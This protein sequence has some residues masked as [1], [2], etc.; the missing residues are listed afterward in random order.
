[1]AS[2][3]HHHPPETTPDSP[4][5]LEE[6]AGE[7]KGILVVKLLSGPLTIDIDHSIPHHQL[8]SP[9]DLPPMAGKFNYE[10]ASLTRAVDPIFTAM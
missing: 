2:D 1:M 9:Q 7:E 5:L 6:Q 10:I 4:P 8:L 3:D